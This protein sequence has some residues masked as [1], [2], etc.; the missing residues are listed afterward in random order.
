MMKLVLFA[1]AALAGAAAACQAAA[2]AAITARAGIGT[3]LMINT[4]VVLVGVS[5]LFV[6]TGGPRTFAQAAGAPWHH[7]I[8]GLC[9]FFIIASITF[10]FPRTGAALA[11]ALMVLGMGAM[12]L[13]VDHF[14]WWGM[15]VIPLSASRVA[16]VILLVSGT[17]FM[18][19]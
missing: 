12:S 19:R 18:R 13:L 7:Y 16:G 4:L 2:N 14:G 17:V 5:V 1:I 10:A 15:P 8:A 11:T 9:G 3:A 6:V